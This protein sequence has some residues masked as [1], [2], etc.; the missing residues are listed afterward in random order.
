M[1]EQALMVKPGVLL[2]EGLPTVLSLPRKVLA[3]DRNKNKL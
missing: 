2:R 3:A 1:T